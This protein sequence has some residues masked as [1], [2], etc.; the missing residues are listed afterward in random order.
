MSRYRIEKCKQYDPSGTLIREWYEILIFKG[1]KRKWFG[2]GSEIEVWQKAKHKVY[3][4]EMIKSP[5]QFSTMDSVEK[6]IDNHEKGLVEKIVREFCFE[7]L[8]N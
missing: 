4:D 6:F 1:V 2:L 7:A 3:G 5:I 8:G